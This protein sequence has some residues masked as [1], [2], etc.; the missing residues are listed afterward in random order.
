MA[1]DSLRKEVQLKQVAQ[2]LQS[3]LNNTRG[4]KT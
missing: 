2:N 4:D 1:E 3:I